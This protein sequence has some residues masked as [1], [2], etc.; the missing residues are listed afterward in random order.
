MN[1][2]V[3]RGK[4]LTKYPILIAMDVLLSINPKFTYRIFERMK[5]YESRKS[6]FKKM[7]IK[8]FEQGLYT[9]N[10]IFVL[11]KLGVSFK[12]I[13][14]KLVLKNYFP[15][16]ALPFYHLS[17]VP[18]GKL[19]TNVGCEKWVESKGSMRNFE[20]LTTTVNYALI[21]IKLSDCC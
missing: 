21:D 4:R 18:F 14:A 20:N 16:L 19:I 1:K 8:L 9:N 11:F 12:S 7:L 13:W 3:I 17:S 5:K 2:H 6:I 15:I 10:Q